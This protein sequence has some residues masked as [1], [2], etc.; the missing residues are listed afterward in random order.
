MIKKKF[1]SI[2]LISSLSL[3]LISCN[4]NNP[5]ESSDETKSRYE[6]LKENE[7]K[8]ATPDYITYYNNGK[9]LTLDS[10]D[11]RFN[12]IVELTN[13]R[14]KNIEGQCKC[15][16][17]LENKEDFINY[18][19]GILEF[20]YLTSQEFSYSLGENDA[21]SNSYNTALFLLGEKD[22]SNETLFLSSDTNF[23][24]YSP[25][26]SPEDIRKILTEN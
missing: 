23:Y 4:M 16:F 3:S 19:G 15:A 7:H 13:D 5:K 22:S 24:S 9:K 8:L 17:P 18:E 6:L 12:K 1:I 21:A 10:S 2:F 14:L 20:S 11:E 25:I 26:S